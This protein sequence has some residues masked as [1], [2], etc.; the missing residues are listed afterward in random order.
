M[1]F[2]DFRDIPLGRTSPGQDIPG[3]ISTA[4]YPWPDIPGKISPSR[5]SP[6]GYPRPMKST[7]PR[8]KN[9]FSRK[10]C[11]RIFDD[12]R[13]IPGGISP[14]GYTPGFLLISR[15]P[16]RPECEFHL[17]KTYYSKAMDLTGTRQSSRASEGFPYL[18]GSPYD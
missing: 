10:F 9:Q 16:R 5:I 13:D 2:K 14:A 15:R 17:R 11:A 1:I 7:A 12:F 8:P 6:A 18:S 3:G 4:G